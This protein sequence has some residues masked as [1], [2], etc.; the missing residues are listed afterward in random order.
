[1]TM[2]RGI[3]IS[4]LVVLLVVILASESSVLG[5]STGNAD[6]E[7]NNQPKSDESNNHQNADLKQ[8]MSDKTHEPFLDA[9]L[10]SSG[11]G[12]V[13]GDFFG[14]VMNVVGGI[15]G[16]TGTG[17]GDTG[18]KVFSTV[19]KVVRIISGI[20]RTVESNFCSAF[21]GL[22]SSGGDGDTPCNRVRGKG[23]NT[24]QD[25]LADEW[26]KSD[27]T[28][29]LVYSQSVPPELDENDMNKNRPERIQNQ[30]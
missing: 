12:S 20:M 4:A 26:V 7:V 19:E 18:R 30:D 13:L 21:G 11:G 16:M 2:P 15:L 5:A 29:K 22:F 10:P 24:T 9:L 23:K 8:G 25:G 6:V 27:D 28:A 3:Q 1:M 17:D 14:T